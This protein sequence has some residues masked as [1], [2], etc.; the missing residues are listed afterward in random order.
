[1]PAVLQKYGAEKNI[2]G[3][4]LGH[5]AIGEAFGAHL[6]NLDQVVHG[7]ATP[8]A[9][10]DT[11]ERLFEGVP[12]VF[13]G[14]RYHSWVVDKERLP[15]CLEV[16]AVDEAGEIMAFRH[17]DYNIHG[18]Q[19]HP[20]SIMTAAGKDILRNFFRYYSSEPIVNV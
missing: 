8:I 12:A 5:Q 2:L 17:K 7:L 16:T 18:L 10:L 20:E 9:V 14:G 11:R 1:M 6:K 4:C 13:E 15:D 19:F 3:V